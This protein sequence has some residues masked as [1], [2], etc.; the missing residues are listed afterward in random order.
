MTTTAI[1]Q[2]GIHLEGNLETL[3]SSTPD[4]QH[5]AI[6]GAMLTGAILLLSGKRKAGLVVSVAATALTL[7]EEQDSVRA[8]WNSLPHHLE[9]AQQFLDHA[10]TT[11]DELVQKR[12]RLRAMFNR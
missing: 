7:L 6:G 12:D 1:P 11:I 9:H 5:L 8:V 2:T 4:W 10:Q 3:S